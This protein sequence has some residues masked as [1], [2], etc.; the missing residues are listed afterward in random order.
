MSR[1]YDIKQT[2]AESHACY[3]PWFS[4]EASDFNPLQ[5]SVIWFTELTIRLQAI[6]WTNADLFNCTSIGHLGTNSSEIAI[7]IK[8]T[9]FKKMYLKTS[10]AR[11]HTF[12]SGL[13]VLTHWGQLTLIR[14]SKLTIIGWDNGL[15]PGRRQAIIST[16]AEILLMGQ[17]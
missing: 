2:I 3:Q 9:S 6:T 7:G 11:C 14:V 15:S 12:C 8:I 4:I 16:N 1:N 10:S 17:N 13:D 5:P